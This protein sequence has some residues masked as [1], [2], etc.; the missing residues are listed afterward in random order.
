MPLCLSLIGNKGVKHVLKHMI[1][2]EIKQNKTWSYIKICLDWMRKS[3][4]CTSFSSYFVVSQTAAFN[5]LFSIMCTQSYLTERSGASSFAL[6]SQ[7][8][9]LKYLLLY[10]NFVAECWGEIN[11]AYYVVSVNKIYLWP[12][13]VFLRLTPHTGYF[14]NVLSS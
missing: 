8:F 1:E 12:G 5:S 13:L 7:I 2:A 6:I 4:S 3:G 11:T 9:F 10:N 14:Q